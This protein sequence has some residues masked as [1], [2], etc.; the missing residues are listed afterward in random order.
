MGLL[1]VFDGNTPS[2]YKSG[3]NLSITSRR[4]GLRMLYIIS[5]PVSESI[6]V[7]L[8]KHTHSRKGNA[9]RTSKVNLLT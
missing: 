9:P 8:A 1:L 2:N 7:H 6:R 5:Y 4:G 3:V